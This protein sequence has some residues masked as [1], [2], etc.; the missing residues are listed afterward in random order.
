MDAKHVP[1]GGG[2]RRAAHVRGRLFKLEAA[3]RALR[4]QD[5]RPT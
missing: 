5:P 2:D 4:D 3:L 1:G